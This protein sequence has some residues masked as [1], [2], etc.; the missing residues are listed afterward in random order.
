MTATLDRTGDAML[1]AV[2]AEPGDDTVRLAFADWLQENGDGGRAEFVRVQVEIH[3][4]GADID[5]DPERRTWLRRRERGLL[6]A[7]NAMAWGPDR[8]L[9]A[10]GM[11]VPTCTLNNGYMPGHFGTM[12]TRG[13]VSGI[14]CPADIWLAHG[15]AVVR[16]QPVEQVRLSDKRPYLLIANEGCLWFRDVPGGGS[17]FSLPPE[18]FDRIDRPEV[19]AGP[20]GDEA[21]K[22]FMADAD[23]EDSHQVEDA[24]NQAAGLASLLWARDS[25]PA[26]ASP[27]GG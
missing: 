24:A 6:T 25:Q 3:R 18:I 11:K 23:G 7:A 14:S 16:C 27:G 10:A 4:L 12:F 15:P 19:S 20:D 21:A 9:W 22:R 8:G 5:V 26:T 1:R 13:F 17:P 2:L